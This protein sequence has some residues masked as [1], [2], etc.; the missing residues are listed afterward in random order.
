VSLASRALAL[1]P[2]HACQI[3]RPTRVAAR[4]KQFLFRERSAFVLAYLQT[5]SL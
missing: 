3:V 2:S 1:M 5:H 4:H